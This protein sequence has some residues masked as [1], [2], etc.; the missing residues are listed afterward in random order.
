MSLKR[1]G[2]ALSEVKASLN[3]NDVTG[4][5]DYEY[6]FDLGTPIKYGAGDVLQFYAPSKSGVDPGTS[7]DI[8]WRFFV[9]TRF[10]STKDPT[11]VLTG[12]FDDS[13]SQ[14]EAYTASPQGP[15]YV[16]TT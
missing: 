3:A 7:D 15:F 8:K 6:V 10:L 16:N 11:K 9:S 13:S 14:A 5:S 1:N 12:I 2:N 4:L